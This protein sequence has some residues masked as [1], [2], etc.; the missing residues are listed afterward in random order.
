M[1]EWEIFEALGDL[2]DELI[3]QERPTRPH[4]KRGGLRLAL[5]AAVTALLVG[6]V[7]G[8]GLGVGVT[9]GKQTVTLQGVSLGQKDGDGTRELSYYTAEVQYDLQTVSVENMELL[10]SQLTQAWEDL[11]HDH[12]GLQAA[13]LMGADGKRRNLGT[14]AGAEEF[15]G[16]DLMQSPDL[17]ALV[18]G[19]YVT[20]VISDPERAEAEYAETGRVTPDGLLIYF[21][22]RRGEAS[23]EA[24]D[25]QLVSESGITV[26]IALTEAFIA[27]E[28]TQRLYSYETEGEFQESGLM[29]D[30]G[31]SILLLENTRE[32][33]FGQTG[34]AA[35]CQNGI[36]YL[37]HMKTYPSSYA[38]PLSLLAPVLQHIQ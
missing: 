36:G 5:I 2:D 13:E 19:A 14:I 29:T 26:Y 38:T 25:A 10:S 16:L 31:K 7:L 18:R 12:S 4:W 23:P 35:W 28:G 20:M 22:L 1:K 37:A 6:T 30:R 11:G 15:F 3:T 27:Q 8:V 17:E 32:G 9:Y 21:S 33:S 24:L 34:Y